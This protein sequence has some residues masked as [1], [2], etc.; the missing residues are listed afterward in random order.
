MTRPPARNRIK[1][2][3]TAS[4]SRSVLAC[5]TW[6]CRPRVRAAVCRFLVF[7]SARAGLV[8]L[9]RCAMVL[10]VGTSSCNNSSRFGATSVFKWVTPVTLPPGRLKLA[11]RSSWTGLAANSTTNRNGRR[12]CPCRK[13][14]RSRGRGYHG[15]LTMNQISRQCGQPFVFIP[16]EAIFDSDV[17]TLDKAC[18]FQTLTERGEELWG[19]AGR[20]GVED[21]DYR[22]RLGL[23]RPRR[24]RPR[25]GAAEQR[26]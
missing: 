26:G 8:G 7:I 3:N 21:P 6:S 14:C 5:R 1:L 17:L 20:P 13:R 25:P 12:R 18:V 11:T 16:G 22:H 2:A 23:P 9:T 10:V 19:V 4:K 24:E 15:H